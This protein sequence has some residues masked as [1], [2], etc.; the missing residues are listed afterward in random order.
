MLPSM[1]PLLLS[2]QINREKFYSF[3]YPENVQTLTKLNGRS[4]QN[5][6]SLTPPKA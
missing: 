6:E 1:L 5:K 3:V 4:I 2:L